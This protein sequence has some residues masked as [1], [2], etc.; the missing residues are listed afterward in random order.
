MLLTVHF[1]RNW[2]DLMRSSY[3]ITNSDTKRQF[4]RDYYTLRVRDNVR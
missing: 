3:K 2:L 1:D 4:Y